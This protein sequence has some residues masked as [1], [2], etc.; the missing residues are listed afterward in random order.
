MGQERLSL[1]LT[2]N[3]REQELEKCRADLRVEQERRGGLTRA[4]TE[5]DRVREIERER[6]RDKES[7]RK[8]QS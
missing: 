3:Q 6:V 2:L 8:R 5:G 4:S 7:K 1:Q